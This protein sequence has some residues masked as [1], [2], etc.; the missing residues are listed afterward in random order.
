MWPRR[1]PAG[2]VFIN[3]ARS[4]RYILIFLFIYMYSV[5]F[6]VDFLYILISLIHL[7]IHFIHAFFKNI[8][9]NF[10]SLN[11]GLS[12]SDCRDHSL[13]TCILIW[14]VWINVNMCNV[15]MLC[16]AGTR[17]LRKTHVQLNLAAENPH[18]QLLINTETQKRV[19]NAY[20][21]WLASHFNF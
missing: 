9:R 10:L 17:R 4:A 20:D 2:A 3:S 13:I 7:F 1:L 11:C 15:W 19:W 21:S 16:Y 6:L 8:F 14:Q 5:R 18:N 12:I